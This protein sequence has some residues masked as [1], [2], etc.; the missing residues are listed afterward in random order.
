MFKHKLSIWKVSLCAE[1]LFF[2]T[3]N[4]VRAKLRKLLTNL[5]CKSKLFAALRKGAL[6]VFYILFLII[7]SFACGSLHFGVEVQKPSTIEIRVILLISFSLYLFY[8]YSHLCRCVYVCICVYVYIYGLLCSK[9]GLG[10]VLQL[11]VE[12]ILIAFKKSELF[13]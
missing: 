5:W 7:V 3:K 11:Q 4:I 13:V 2:S 12:E 8:I 9:D 1:Q 10:L 6:E